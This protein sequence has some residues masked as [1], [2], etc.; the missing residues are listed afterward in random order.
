MKGGDTIDSTQLML[1]IAAKLKGLKYGRVEIFVQDG[2]VTQ[3]NRVE[4]EKI[5]QK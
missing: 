3:I 5:E 1:Q 4:Q 2:K